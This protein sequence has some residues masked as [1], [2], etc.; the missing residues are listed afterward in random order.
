MI[1]KLKKNDSQWTMESVSDPLFKYEEHGLEIS[2][3][4]FIG[5]DERKK[6][7]N[8]Y[9]K[10]NN[11]KHEGDIPDDVYN[12]AG[13]AVIYFNFNGFDEL[14]CTS[15]ND[16]L[17]KI[18]QADKIT[19][20]VYE[21]IDDDDKIKGYVFIGHDISLSVYTKKAPLDRIKNILKA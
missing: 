8:D 20:G 1:R 14:F 15:T 12:N 3:M 7:I 11:I 16:F 13:Y 17:K 10:K 21:E 2:F 19:P 6:H 4:I 18:N 5:D 9:M